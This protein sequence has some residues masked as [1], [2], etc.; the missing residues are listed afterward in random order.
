ME[1]YKNDYEINLKDYWSDDTHINEALHWL[2]DDN[3]YKITNESFYI[4]KIY[5]IIHHHTIGELKELYNK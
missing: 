4:N 3:G 5:A 2:V 1:N